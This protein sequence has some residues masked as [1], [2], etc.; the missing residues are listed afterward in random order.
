MRLAPSFR[1]CRANENALFYGAHGACCMLKALQ[2]QPLLAKWNEIGK[3][4]RGSVKSFMMRVE[5]L[6]NDLVQI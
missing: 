5:H 1:D 2:L 6:K 4:V 3:G